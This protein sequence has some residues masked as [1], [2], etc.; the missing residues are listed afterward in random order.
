M[1]RRNLVLALAGFALT[2]C[3]PAPPMSDPAA[4]LAAI[5]AVREGYAAA[6]KAGDAAKVA[7]YLTADAYDM[8]NAMETMVGSQA[9]ETG[10]RGMMEQFAADIAITSEKTDVSGD[11]AYDRGKYRTALTPKAGGNPMVEEGRYLVV[12]K[13]QADS[14]WKLVELMGNLATP[15]APAGR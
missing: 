9:F 3:T 11:L 1:I 2:A 14:S 10:L 12:L 13:R 7:S 6:F 8:E 4:D 15:P 5:T